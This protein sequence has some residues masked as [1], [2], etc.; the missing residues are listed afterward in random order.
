MYFQKSTRK[1]PLDNI[2]KSSKVIW[3][4]LAALKWN[5]NILKHEKYFLI[6]ISKHFC[7]RMIEHKDASMYSYQRMTK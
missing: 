1:S 6:K 2:R 7:N 4:K 3:D 5:E